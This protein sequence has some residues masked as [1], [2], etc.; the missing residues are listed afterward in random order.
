M[1]GVAIL[2]VKTASTKW[3]HT[4]LVVLLALLVLW[5]LNLLILT[6]YWKESG[7]TLSDPHTIGEMISATLR[8]Y[9]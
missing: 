1:M 8:F 4:S 2:L 3:L 6:R 7:I 9:W 5:N